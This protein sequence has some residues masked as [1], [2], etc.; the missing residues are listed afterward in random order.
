VREALVVREG[1]K[2]E[3]EKERLLI[4]KDLD[5]AVKGLFFPREL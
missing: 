1:Q 3:S 2:M 5:H 4:L